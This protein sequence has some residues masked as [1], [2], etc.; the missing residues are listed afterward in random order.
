MGANLRTAA[1]LAC[2]RRARAFSTQLRSAF[3]AAAKADPRCAMAHWGDAMADS[4]P[5][6]GEEQVQSAQAALARQRT[7]QR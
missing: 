1:G 2:G 4:Y 3:Q 5:I 7:S 6:W